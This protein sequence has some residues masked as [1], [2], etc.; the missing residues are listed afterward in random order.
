MKNITK[1]SFRWQLN[2]GN[3]D[4]CIA[5]SIS[6]DDAMHL[7]N[8]AIEK[9]QKGISKGVLFFLEH[10]PPVITFGRHASRDSLLLSENE[11]A[12]LGYQIRYASRG[13]FVTVHEPGQ[14]VIYV[15]VPIKPK[16]AV[17]FVSH[18]IQLTAQFL[19]RE[20]NIAT[21]CEISPPGLWWNGKKI[22]FCGFDFTGGISRHGIAINVCN[23]M[24]G[25]SMIIPCGMP[26]LQ[27]ISLEKI[28]QKPISCEEFLRRAANF[29]EKH[30]YP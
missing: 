13:G 15:V 4:I 7:Q 6:Y 2:V 22:C 21:H 19:L 29:F 14:A 25:F 11:I 27:I 10:N 1:N 20:Y 8:E 23:S 28:L 18:I 24:K 16:A 17:L 9:I 26:N 30:F 3:I 12:N 5:T